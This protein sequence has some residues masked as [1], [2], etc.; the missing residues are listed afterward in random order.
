MN[1]R[2]SPSPSPLAQLA[3]A[4]SLLGCGGKDSYVLGSGGTAVVGADGGAAPAARGPSPDASGAAPSADAAGSAA[5]VGA[6]PW[7][8]CGTLA[9]GSQASGAVRALAVS[10]DGRFA[11]AAVPVG[12]VGGAEVHVWRLDTGAL[13]RS[14]PPSYTRSLA[15]SPDGTAIA[16]TSDGVDVLRV[17][18]AARLWEVA[19]PGVLPAP[20][21]DP[22][23]A[24][25]PSGA[26]VAVAGAGGVVL[27]SASTGAAVAELAAAAPAGAVAFSPDGS[28]VATSAAELW[29]VQGRRLVWRGP[30]APSARDAVEVEAAVAF[31]PDGRRIAVSHCAYDAG[32]DEAC[33]G[34]THVLRASDGSV[35]RTVPSLSGRPSFSP[36]GRALLAGG[37]LV[38]LDGG[39]ELSLPGAATSSTFLPDGRILAGDASGVVHLLCAGKPD[40]GEK[41][42]GAGAPSNGGRPPLPAA[43]RVFEG[44]R[45]PVEGAACATDGDTAACCVDDA[46]VFFTCRAANAPAARGWR[47]GTDVATLNATTWACVSR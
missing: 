12:K 10:R 37:R 31:S 9:H 33:S 13:V 6:R 23:V 5:A 41:P 39:T 26:L 1:M 2:K 45:C 22:G 44:G 36:D 43:I 11:A 46:A 3:L 47:A 30:K 19:P 16:A 24:F 25:S 35:E 8:R 28:V 17:A 20:G 21:L 40:G 15:L 34:P 18:D 38:D 29:D 27:R 42:P 14:L 32:L 7:E 4:L